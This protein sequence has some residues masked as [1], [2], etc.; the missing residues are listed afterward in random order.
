MCTE[1]VDLNLIVRDLLRDLIR[2]RWAGSVK[3]AAEKMGVPQRTL[4]RFMDDSGTN[5]GKLD[6]L[7]TVV[8]GLETDIITFLVAHEAFSSL[9]PT[10]ERNCSRAHCER[11]QRLLSPEELGDAVNMIESGMRLGIHEEVIAVVWKMIKT[12]RRVRARQAPVASRG[13]RK[14][15]RALKSAKPQQK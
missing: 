9:R 8:S 4:A 1:S 12:T 14:A 2:D 10:W 11:L 6:M 7:S 13:H 15:P 3:K 5:G